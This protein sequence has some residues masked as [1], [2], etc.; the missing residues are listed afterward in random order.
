MSAAAFGGAG[1]VGDET[2]VDFALTP[3]SGTNAY[4]NDL[5]TV[6]TTG[7]YDVHLYGRT[8]AGGST[9]TGAGAC[10]GVLHYHAVPDGGTTQPQVLF[11]LGYVASGS[12]AAT[13]EAKSILLTDGEILYLRAGWYGS[14]TGKLMNWRL[15]VR[16]R[17]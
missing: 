8:V 6:P 5:F 12:L 11:A 10:H 7:L 14:G 9:Y 15:T 3:G 17:F 1:A 2:L 16:P 4:A 13:A